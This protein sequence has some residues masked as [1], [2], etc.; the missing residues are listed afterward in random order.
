MTTR[1]GQGRVI[2]GVATDGRPEIEEAAATT[3]GPDGSIERRSLDEALDERDLT[4][5]LEDGQNLLIDD[6]IPTVREPGND[7]KNSSPTSADRDAATDRTN[8]L[9]GAPEARAREMGETET[10]GSTVVQQATHEIKTGNQVVHSADD[11]LVTH[12][13]PSNH[14]RHNPVPSPV[15]PGSLSRQHVSH[16]QF[17]KYILG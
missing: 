16:F 1:D 14:L 11:K 7:T 2:Q 12:P 15:S 6:T 17:G 5:Q 9:Q 13:Q 8:K 3:A 4:R 10:F